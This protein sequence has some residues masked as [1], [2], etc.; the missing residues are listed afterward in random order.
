MEAAAGVDGELR[1]SRPAL[2]AAAPDKGTT[3]CVLGRRHLQSAP[4]TAVTCIDEE[5]LRAFIDEHSDVL[6]PRV[7]TWFE[8]AQ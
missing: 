4:P 5:G 3:L 8:L 1:S 6:P 7:R 2:A